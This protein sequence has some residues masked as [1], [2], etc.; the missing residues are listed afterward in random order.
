MEQTVSAMK[1]DYVKRNLAVIITISGKNELPYEPTNINQSKFSFLGH[2]KYS[3]A[4]I[5][6]KQKKFKQKRRVTFFSQSIN[7]ITSH[8]NLKKI[9]THR[10]TERKMHQ[11]ALDNILGFCKKNHYD[12]HIRYH[13]GTDEKESRKIYST[14]LHKNNVTI[15]SS[16]LEEDLFS[17]EIAIGFNTS[18]LY[19]AHVLGKRF[20]KYI[21][22]DL[23]PYFYPEFPK[24]NIHNIEESLL[25]LSSE[26]EKSID[27]TLLCNFEKFIKE[28][29]SS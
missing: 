24:T 11:I 10:E 4:Q 19:E 14:W 13:P 6:K 29:V 17:S 28:G 27:L 15:S 5:T 20:F 23:N 18:C 2:P 25:K 21:P 26:K 22:P 12:F 3:L 7:G 1:K 9:N 16:E 8:K